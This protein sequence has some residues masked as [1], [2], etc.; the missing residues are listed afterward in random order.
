MI[1]LKV[2]FL[3]DGADYI[4]KKAKVRTNYTLAFNLYK[5]QILQSLQTKTLSSKISFKVLIKSSSLSI[6]WIYNLEGSKVKSV[7]NAKSLEEKE[8]SDKYLKLLIEESNLITF[9]EELRRIDSSF[10]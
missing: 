1:F 7:F 9:L 6:I 10:L 2:N 5:L 8:I 4:D 3:Q